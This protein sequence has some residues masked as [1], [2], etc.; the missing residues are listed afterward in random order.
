M[1]FR[2]FLSGSVYGA[3]ICARTAA[4]ALIS[5]DDVLTVAFGNARY[6]ASI[7]ASAAA[8]ALIGNL[9]CHDKQPP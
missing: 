9:V 2:L 7:C 6:G 3:S 5:I 8:D 4:D 1:F